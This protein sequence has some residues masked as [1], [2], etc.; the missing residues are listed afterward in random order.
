MLTGKQ[1]VVIKKH[2]RQ[3]SVCVSY[4]AKNITLF[5][6]CIRIGWYCFIRFSIFLKTD[7]PVSKCYFRHFCGYQAN[8]FF[9]LPS[10]FPGTKQI[11]SGYPKSAFSSKSSMKF[12]FHRRCSLSPSRQK[13]TIFLL[14]RNHTNG[15]Q[16]PNTKILSHSIHILWSTW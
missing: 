9:R 1:L 5:L 16:Q 15:W 14:D 6:C 10:I 4:R 13:S 8:N 2:R 11:F 7:F 3:H 12:I